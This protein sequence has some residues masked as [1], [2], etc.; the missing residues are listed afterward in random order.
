[1]ELAVNNA[2]T[3]PGA[4][5]HARHA[6]R[7]RQGRHRRLRRRRDRRPPL[8]LA[9]LLPHHPAA[10]RRHPVRAVHQRPHRLDGQPAGQPEGQLPDRR[11]TTPPDPADWLA[12]A[13][14][15]V[16]GT[17]WHDYVG[18][19]AER[20]GGEQG[21]APAPRRRRPTSRWTPPPAPMSLTAEAPGGAGPCATVA[22]GGQ[23]LRG[24]RPARRRRR[25]P[26]CCCAT[27]SAPAWRRC[28]R[29]STPST[30]DRGG[31]LRRARRRRLPAAAVPLPDRRAGPPGRPR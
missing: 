11:R 8:P 20:T 16:K 15:E 23:Q 6:G 18:W 3:A 30:R 1:M 29:W 27:A 5:A 9:V 22:V 26:R 28:S 13:A 24:G 14:T 7:P 21:P 31:P 25:A 4:A 19:L 2:L 10:R 17:W 12:Q